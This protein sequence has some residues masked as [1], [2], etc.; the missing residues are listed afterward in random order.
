MLRTEWQAEKKHIVGP[1][2]FIKLNKAIAK[3]VSTPN[4]VVSAVIVGDKTMKDLYKKWKGEAKATDVL[5]F[6][7][8]ESKDENVLK[9]TKYLGEIILNYQQAKRQ[10]VQRNHS[11]RAELGLVYVHGVLHLLGYDHQNARQNATMRELEKKI[12]T[13]HYLPKFND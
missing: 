4:M 5:S 10:S 3:N 12:T 2:F 9:S 7:F 11:L 6:A 13:T 1:V 8:T